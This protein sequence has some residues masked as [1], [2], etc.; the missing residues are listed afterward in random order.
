MPW[1]D[2]TVT[3]DGTESATVRVKADDEDDAAGVA[4][5]V[6]DV[7]G[8][9]ERDDG[10]FHRPYL[11]D[12]DNGVVEVEGV[13]GLPTWDCTLADGFG[14]GGQTDDLVKWVKA[15]CLEAALWFARKRRWRLNGTPTR[16][17]GRD[18]RV[19]ADECDGV[20][21]RGE[22]ADERERRA[23]ARGFGHLCIVR[24]APLTGQ[25][26]LVD[27]SQKAVLVTTKAGMDNP[28]G[29]RE[30]LITDEVE[31]AAVR[32]VLGKRYQGE[33]CGWDVLLEYLSTAEELSC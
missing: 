17:E 1:F 11:P 22:W 12:A 6:A 18:E 4:L 27:L 9:F 13:D 24:D 5:E 26:A 7:E 19:S 16:L 32:E 31:M 2:V 20:V 8:D 30:I 33:F 10:N 14:P 28:L 25:D 3:R 23:E 29:L 21:S 15:P